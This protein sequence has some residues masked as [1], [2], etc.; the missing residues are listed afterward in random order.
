MLHL[1]AASTRPYVRY[2]GECVGRWGRHQGG[3]ARRALQGLATDV[4]VSIGSRSRSDVQT[5]GWRSPRGAPL[6][7]FSSLKPPPESAGPPCAPGSRP[8]GGAEAGKTDQRGGAWRKETRRT[9]ALRCSPPLSTFRGASEGAMLL[10]AD[11]LPP[12]GGE[13]VGRRSSTP[14]PPLPFFPIEH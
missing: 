13:D 9:G 1:A 6:V 14:T 8:R 3:A 10:G 2:W 7:G 4:R 11:F 5:E 12:D